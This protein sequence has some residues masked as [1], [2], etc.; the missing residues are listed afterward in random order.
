MFPFRTV[1]LPC[2]VLCFLPLSCTH[3]GEPDKEGA[4]A[5]EKRDIPT[6]DGTVTYANAR[7]GFTLRHP[8]GWK[9]VETILKG[10]FLH[11]NVTPAE[12]VIT[13][14]EVAGEQA[15][16]QVPAV[17]AIPQG[18]RSGWRTG[19]SSTLD[20]NGDAFPN[21]GFTLD[22][23][24]STVLRLESGEIFGYLLFPE[25]PPSSWAPEGCLFAR[26]AVLDGTTRCLDANGNELPVDDCRPYNEERL[27]HTGRV[28][29][30]SKR[31]IDAILASWSFNTSLQQP[32]GDL[33]RIGQPLP[34]SDVASPLSFSGEARGYYYFEADFPVR[35]EDSGGNVLAQSPARA[36]GDWMTE[37]WVPFSGSLAFDTPAEEQGYLVFERANPSGLEENAV[38]FRLPVRFGGADQ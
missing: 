7:F 14:D 37:G 17:L 6:V 20:E 29:P 38:S 13:E 21:A 23:R 35:L 19:T 1:S 30:A 15:I 26:Y 9:T 5:Q 33:I 8:A 25:S 10:Q 2:L 16:H 11:L 32:I 12:S 34:N 18:I 28:D 36:V 24:S 4:G 22:T 3:T 27:V 31:T